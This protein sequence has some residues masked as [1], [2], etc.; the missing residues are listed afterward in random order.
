MINCVVALEKSQG[1]GFQNS[2]PWPRLKQDLFWFKKLTLDNIVIM[3]SNTWHSLDY[4]LPD[5]I[6][7]VLSRFHQNGSTFSC[8]NMD[9]ALD[10]CNIRYPNKEIFIIGGQAVYDSTMNIIEKFYITEIDAN[11]QCDKFFNLKYVQ[12]RFTNVSTIQ[13]HLEPVPFTIK[14]YSKND[15]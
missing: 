6:N 13:T 7:I 12:D 3:G 5:R 10:L 1:I 9:E 11:Y 14:E 4:P 8:I 2:M 15:Y